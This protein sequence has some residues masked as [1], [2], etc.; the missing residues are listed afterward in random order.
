MMPLDV[1]VKIFLQI[2]SRSDM[3]SFL[4]TCKYFYRITERYD[5]W[6]GLYERF[7]GSVL[8][9]PDMETLSYA[10]KSDIHTV[11]LEG[12]QSIN[13]KEIQK[14]NK[15]Y[16]E[17]ILGLFN[18]YGFG[19]VIVHRG[20]SEAFRSFD[21]PIGNTRYLESSIMNYCVAKHNKTRH[22]HINLK[23]SKY[24]LEG[25]C[26]DKHN[27]LPVFLDFVEWLQQFFVFERIAICYDYEPSVCLIDAKVKPGATIE[28]VE[29]TDSW[30]VYGCIRILISQ[31]RDPTTLEIL[32]RDRPHI[33]SAYLGNGGYSDDIPIDLT[34]Y[35]VIF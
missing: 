17:E 22:L 27:I 5:L 31:N 34:K 32:D 16:C 25:Y 1:L 13:I 30:V 33:I 28:G 24:N 21:Q 20:G 18:V 12:V 15:S 3:L 35:Q 8:S 4:L 2:E 19:P 7:N 23:N 6:L 9:Y 26:F 14:P 10:F 29:I 11:S